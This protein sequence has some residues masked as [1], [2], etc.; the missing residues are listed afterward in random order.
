MIL[1]LIFIA[2]SLFFWENYRRSHVDTTQTEKPE[3]PPH[4]KRKNAPAASTADKV[5]QTVKIPAQ[6]LDIPENI[7]RHIK[8]RHWYNAK[9]P[10]ATSRF[11]Q[12]L[13]M[14]KLNDL[15]TKTIKEGSQRP[16]KKGR[17]IHQY[18]FSYPIGV[19]SK[20]QEAHSLRVVT[21]KENKVI[22]A[23]PVK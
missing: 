20:G 3:K 22:T 19:T 10:E 5:D 9:T 23:F 12:D 21:D 15:A 8:E 17:S 18:R 7:Q 1:A 6:Q 11:N 16:S 2:V 13:T 14:Q 4:Y